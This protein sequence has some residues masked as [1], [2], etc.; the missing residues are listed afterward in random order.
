[1]TVIIPKQVY[2]TVVAASVRFA[3]RKVPKDEW[4]EASGIFIGKNE[5]ENVSISKAYPIMHQELDKNA[6]IDKYKWS[7]EDMVIASDI[8][9]DAYARNEFIVGWWH[10]HPDFGIFLSH[11]D[12]RTTLS[13][14]E[15]NPL[16]IALVFDPERLLRQIE[17]PIKKGDPE[18]QLKNDPGIKIFRLDDVKR[19][20]EASYHEVNF[21]IDGY[22]DLEHLVKQTQNFIANLTNFFPKESV[23]QTYEIFID[24]RINELNSML[25]GTEE[26]LQTLMRKGES[27][28]VNQVLGNQTIEIRKYVAETFIKIE[29]IKQFMD[30]LEYKER[31]VIVPSVEAVISKWD[32][33]ILNLNERLSQMAR[34]C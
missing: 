7:D 11:I 25:L 3:N 28:R 2:L 20:I 32:E 14:Q 23:I 18:K 10:S 17:K 4:L 22:D 24:E 30:Y 6:V 16:A 8:E 26:Y 1:M 21:R 13:Y 34:I 19:G 27:H 9:L 15:N 12:I 31:D 29:N 33:V 5:G